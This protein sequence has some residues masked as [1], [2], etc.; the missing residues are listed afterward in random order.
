MEPSIF[1]YVGAHF[2]ATLLFYH[3]LLP[4]DCLAPSLQRVQRDPAGLRG[5]YVLT[6]RLQGLLLR[7]PWQGAFASRDSRGTV[8]D[9][10]QSWRLCGW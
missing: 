5:F 8:L 2:T 4:G 9:G 3:M 10:R 6:R 1:A 7:R